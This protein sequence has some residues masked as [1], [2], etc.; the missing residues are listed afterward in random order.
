MKS[1]LSEEKITEKNNKVS[2]FR[3]TKLWFVDFSPMHKGLRGTD[4]AD[5]RMAKG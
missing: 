3:I 4:K 2:P 1:H 5:D